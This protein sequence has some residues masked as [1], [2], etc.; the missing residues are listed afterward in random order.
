MFDLLL[1][2]STY[3]AFATLTLMEVVLGVDNVIFI[4]VLI[5]RLPKA[6]ADQ[7]RTIGLSLALIFRIV[8]L[9]LLA[10]ISHLEQ[11]LFNAFGHGFSWRDLILIAGGLFL[12]YKA[13]HEMHAEI[14]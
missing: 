7:A 1:Q 2:P 9:L 3:I 14:E 5:S 13:V 4:S 6:Q 12:I 8:L 11:P 10:W